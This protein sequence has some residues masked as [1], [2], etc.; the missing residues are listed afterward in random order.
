MTENGWKPK[1]FDDRFADVFYGNFRTMSGKSTR[2]VTW[3]TY[4]VYD[5]DNKIVNQTV[6]NPPFVADNYEADFFFADENNG[7]EFKGFLDNG[8]A[9]TFVLKNTKISGDK[10]KKNLGC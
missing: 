1:D 5:K 7:K 3:I 9:K 8:E 10:T 2:P 4:N 6:P